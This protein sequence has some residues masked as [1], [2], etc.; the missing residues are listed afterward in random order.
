MGSGLGECEVLLATLSKFGEN[1]LGKAPDA[2]PEQI[3]Q[4]IPT[5]MHVLHVLAWHEP[6]HQGQAHITLNL[7]NATQK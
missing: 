7:W 4:R 3:R 6:H 2:L 1:D 5:L